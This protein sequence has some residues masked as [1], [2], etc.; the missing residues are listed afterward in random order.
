MKEKELPNYSG[1]LFLSIENSLKKFKTHSFSSWFWLP[2]H[3]QI[4]NQES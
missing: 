2:L 4:R 1:A 3:T